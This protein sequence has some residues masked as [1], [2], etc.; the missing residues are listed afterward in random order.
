LAFISFKL[1]IF[2]LFS[3]FGA[4]KNTKFVFLEARKLDIPI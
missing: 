3:Y 1:M 4:W 2:S